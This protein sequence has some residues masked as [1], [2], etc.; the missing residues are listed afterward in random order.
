MQLQDFGQ[1][2]SSDGH[3]A[4]LGQQ[5]NGHSFRLDKMSFN[6]GDLHCAAKGNHRD[7]EDGDGQNIDGCV[8]GF[9][10]VQDAH[11]AVG[12]DAADIKGVDYSHMACCR[13]HCGSSSNTYF[14]E[15]LSSSVTETKRD[16]KISG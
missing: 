13:I 4:E 3:N 8:Y 2:E 1:G 5:C 9:G 10:D 14:T 16:K 12:R 6:F 15:L 7:D 11:A